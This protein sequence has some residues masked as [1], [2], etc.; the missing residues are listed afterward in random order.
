[1]GLTR[2]G[3]FFVYA[4]SRVLTWCF[5]KGPKPYPPSGAGKIVLEAG[6]RGWSEPAPGL[7]ELEQSAVEYL[8]PDSV[9]RFSV[10]GTRP[11]L[12][13]VLDVLRQERPTHYFYDT[14]TGSQHPFWGSVQALV[15]AVLFAY[16]SVVP[17]TILTNLPARRWRRQVA[18]VT[19]R[20]GLI[21]I[22]MS[23]AQVL[24]V[25]PHRRV[26]G[27]I[28]MPF[29]QQRLNQIRQEIQRSP[30]AKV[31]PTLTF[32][33]SVYE[34]RRSTLESLTTEFAESNISFEIFARDPA[35][36]KID[37]T[38]YWTVLRE[39]EFLLTTS[40]HIVKRGADAGSP[41]HM[42]YRYTEALIAECCLVAP[43][44]GTALIPLQ[45]FVPFTDAPELR[46]TLEELTKSP[47]RVERIRREGAN[48]M[49]DRIENQLWWREVD[50]ALGPDRLLR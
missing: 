4:V 48:F 45:H 19:A 30:G 5:W 22:L 15:L 8:G 42:V 13:Q 17:L 32:I 2:A 27:P 10:R 38:T 47:Q 1:M 44:L 28:F 3:A 35:G 39:S 21:L 12:S 49:T 36:P 40:D 29:S 6:E 46:E 34:P 26:L 31:T 9:V 50:E 41:P 11:Y 24:G 25:L 43:D 16:Y 7:L 23:P 14:R 20:R 18:A 37:Q 33:G